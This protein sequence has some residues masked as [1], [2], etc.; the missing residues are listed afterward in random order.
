MLAAMFL[1]GYLTDRVNRPL[2][3]GSIYL[4]RSLS[5][6]VLMYVGTS[7]EMMLLFA[8]IYGIFDYSTVPP[9]ASRLSP[10]TLTR[11]HDLMVKARVLEER[12]ITMYKQGDGYFWIGGPPPSGLA[13][14]GTDY[15]AVVNRRIAVTPIHLD[16][17]GRR[18]LRRRRQA[19]VGRH[20]RCRD[21]RV[22]RDGR[23]M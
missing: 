13:V 22:R 20:C 19:G 7:Y 4:V 14:P 10:E 5:F 23:A 8:V 6:I 3:L 17:T 12:L 1:S 11:V 15:H 18:L 16:L 9:T 21:V 2:L